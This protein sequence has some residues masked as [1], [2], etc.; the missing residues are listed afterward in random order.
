ML[1]SRRADR[2]VTPSMTILPQGD[3]GAVDSPI[4]TTATLGSGRTW[5]TRV[6]L[7]RQ[8]AQ[9]GGEG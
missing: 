8:R 6:S 7:E 2:T 9:G 4:G 3:L 5:A 1:G